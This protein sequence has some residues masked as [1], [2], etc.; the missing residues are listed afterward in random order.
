VAGAIMAVS[1]VYVWRS[2]SPAAFRKAEAA[3]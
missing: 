2:L 1:A 3:V